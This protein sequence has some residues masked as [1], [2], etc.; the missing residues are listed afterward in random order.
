MLVMQIAGDLSE[1]LLR[2]LAAGVLETAGQGKVTVALVARLPGAKDLAQTLSGEGVF[3]DI[4]ANEA[5]QA[6]LV[7]FLPAF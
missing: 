5:K 7:R 3:S 4:R 1:L 6:G 2:A